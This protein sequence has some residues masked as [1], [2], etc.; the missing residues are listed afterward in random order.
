MSKLKEKDSFAILNQKMVL[1][2]M[3]NDLLGCSKG[4]CSR[5]YAINQKPVDSL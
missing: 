4:F 2:T 3:N 1:R 5:G